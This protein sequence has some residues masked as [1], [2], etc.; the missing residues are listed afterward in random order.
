MQLSKT[1]PRFI[2][3]G[4]GTGGHIYPAIALADEITS[5]LPQA[6]VLFVGA[7]GKMEMEK[8]PK[9]GYSIKGLWISGFDRSNMTSN[10]SF[11]LKVGKSL[12]EAS[13]IVKKFKPDVAIGTGGFA[14][15]PVMWAAARKKIPVLIQE[16]NSLPG[17]TNKLLR[18]KAFAVCTAYD[19]MEKYFN[20]DKLHVTG[21][22][23]RSE[24]F[25]NLSNQREA[26][27]SFN[28]DP[29]KPVILNIGGSLGARS[30]NEA[31]ANDLE[32]LL[33]QD[34]QLIW[35][36]GKLQYNQ[37]KDNPKTKHS[38]IH[39]TEFIYNMKEAFAAADIIVSR[40]GAMAI[41]ELTIVAKPTILVPFPFAAEDHQTVNA[42][43]LAMREAAIMIPDADAK[44]ALVPHS[45]DLL[46]NEPKRKQLAQNIEALGK[47]NATSEIVDIV[48]EKLNL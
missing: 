28:L 13:G 15:G 34:F 3:S 22:P 26:K 16:Q 6:E 25:W 39:V 29:D 31:W 17:M 32:Q 10:L 48:F 38:N 30:L 46:N 9:A 5:R 33:E 7:K 14:S 45:I 12:W 41:S 40:A 18:N 1:S 4:G 20:P 8:V 35:Q 47:P 11:P 27:K 19:N 42:Q 21:N 23:I 24:L 37:I 43:Q 44:N 36:T 2:I